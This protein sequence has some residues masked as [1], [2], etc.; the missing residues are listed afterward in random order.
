MRLSTLAAA[1]LCI[2]AAAC[3]QDHG[4]HD[5]HDA[6]GHAEHDHGSLLR[7]G[8]SLVELS[9]HEAFLEVLHDRKDGVVR[10]WVTTESGAAR[11]A[12]SPPVLNLVVAGTPAQVEGS[13]QDGAWVFRDEVLR[14]DPDSMRLRLSIGGKP[15]SPVLETRG[16]TGK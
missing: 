1:L 2:A 10:V 11:A 4:T 3:N 15:Y 16:D 6:E 14:G 7:H 5:G 9:G 8:G 12:D 13:E